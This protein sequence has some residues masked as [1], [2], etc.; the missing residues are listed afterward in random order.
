MNGSGEVIW[1]VPRL[2]GRT[3]QT[4]AVKAGKGCS[5]WSQES[6]LSA[7]IWY[8]RFGVSRDGSDLAKAPK[9]DGAMDMGPVRN[10]AYSMAIPILP[11]SDPARWFRVLVPLGRSVV[12]RPFETNRDFQGLNLLILLRDAKYRPP[13]MEI[14]S[15][16]EIWK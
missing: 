16:L 15:M 1:I 10:N 5:G 4:L 12:Q 11:I 8:C 3:L 9:V 6:R 14:N 13:S 2:S 7:W